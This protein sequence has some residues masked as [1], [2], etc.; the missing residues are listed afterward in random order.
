MTKI[1]TPNLIDLKVMIKNIY[2][3]IYKESD[4]IDDLR[5]FDHCPPLVL[6]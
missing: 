5:Y 1:M 3:E 6:K 4:S 2:E